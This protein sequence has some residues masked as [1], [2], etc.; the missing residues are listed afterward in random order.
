MCYIK[1]VYTNSLIEKDI[2]IPTV[3]FCKIYHCNILLVMIFTIKYCFEV[4]KEEKK[5]DIRN[6]SY[7]TFDWWILIALFIKL[8]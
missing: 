3:N 6:V 8:V 7:V 4:I 5:P 2:H 1:R